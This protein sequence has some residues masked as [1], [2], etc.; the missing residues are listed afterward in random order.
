LPKKT[1]KLEIGKRK[2]KK[3]RR[4]HQEFS[5]KKLV[6]LLSALR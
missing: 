4:E 5:Q 6:E 2:E 1:N 3:R